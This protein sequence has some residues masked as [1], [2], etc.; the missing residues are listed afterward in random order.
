MLHCALLVPTPL[1]LL[2][3]GHA[4]ARALRAGLAEAGHPAEIIAL[5][6]ERP[7]G[8]V[9]ERL[10]PEVTPIIDGR[11]LTAFA[12]DADALSRHRVVGLVHRLASLESGLPEEKVAPLRDVEHRLL[13][14]LARIIVPSVAVADALSREFAVEA[15]RI[16]VVA[17]GS[18]PAARSPGSGERGCR[19]LSVGA[20]VPRKGH[21]VLLRA[22]ARLFDLDWSLALVGSDRRD[23]ACA[24]SLRAQAE[25]LGIGERIRFAGE[26]SAEA[27]EEEWQCADLF[28]L[29]SP[30]EGCGMAIL[31]ARRHGLPVALIGGGSAAGMVTPATGISAAPGDEATYSKSLRRMIFDRDLRHDL[32]NASWVEAQTLPDWQTQ[33]RLFAE[34]LA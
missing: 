22:L 13:A 3:G 11:V 15:E 1:A 20:L 16:R 12:E 33:A 19:L 26:V 21:D 2:S 23:P 34:A 7:A 17:P 25:S 5:P 4:Y 18:E 9:L 6:A 10:A 14:R 27:L 30:W 32:A 28:A 8:E 31:Q 29:A 24:A